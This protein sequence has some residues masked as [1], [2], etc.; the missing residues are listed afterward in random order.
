[1]R[2][3]RTYTARALCRVDQRRGIRKMPLNIE[4]PTALCT[5]ADIYDRLV[6]VGANH[7]AALTV[8]EARFALWAAADAVCALCA[9]QGAS[10]A[11][12]PLLMF[13]PVYHNTA[14]PNVTV[15]EGEGHGPRKVRPD[16]FA[17]THRRMG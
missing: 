5:V 14:G 7:S 9:V 15:E 16:A 10:Q 8:H 11:P 4:R 6:Q 17:R 1:M 13:F 2:R 3:I 12:L